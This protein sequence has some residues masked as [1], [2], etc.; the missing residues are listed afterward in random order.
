M[1]DLSKKQFLKDKARLE[2]GTQIQFF[3][4]D[5]DNF[6]TFNLILAGVM[7]LL[8]YFTT[9]PVDILIGATIGSLTT[10]LIFYIKFGT[11]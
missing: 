1:R 7:G 4:F 3:N 11:K 10:L 9:I 6:I 2:F 5:F 8:F